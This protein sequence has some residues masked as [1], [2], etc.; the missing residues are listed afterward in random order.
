MIS[1][2]KNGQNERIIIPRAGGPQ[3]SLLGGQVGVMQGARVGHVAGQGRR[4]WRTRQL[5]EV[6]GVGAEGRQERAL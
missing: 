2:K 3:S 1:S 6:L 5:G 4:G